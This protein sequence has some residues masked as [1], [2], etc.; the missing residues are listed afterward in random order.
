M[1]IIVPHKYYAQKNSYSFNFL[2][3]RCSSFFQLY[4]LILFTLPKTCV[5]YL[6]EWQL[7]WKSGGR[8]GRRGGER[9]EEV[10]ILTIEVTTCIISTDWSAYSAHPL[11]RH[12]ILQFHNAS[13]CQEQ[14]FLLIQGL[15][16]KLISHSVARPLPIEK[17]FQKGADVYSMA[18]RD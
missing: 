18:H 14:A 9:E 8:G 6:I 13:P 4:F 17:C 2:L 3:I 10:F 1:C 15:Q 7:G 16:Q 11:I 5:V 12:G